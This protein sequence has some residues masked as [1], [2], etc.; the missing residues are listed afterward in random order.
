SP[1]GGYKQSG[2]GREMGS[3]ALDNYTEVKSVWINLED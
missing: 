2:L 3:Y 1:F